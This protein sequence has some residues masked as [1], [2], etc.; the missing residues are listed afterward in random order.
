M[1]G[2]VIGTLAG[3][4]RIVDTI[5]VGG[6]GTVYR[7]EHT[8]LGP[9]RGGEG[10]QPGDVDDAR[11]RQSLLQRGARDHEHQAPRHRRGVRLRLPASRA[12]A[13]IV[14]E[15]LEGEPLARRATRARPRCPRARPRRSCAASA[16]R[17]PPRTPRASSTA[18]SSPTTSSS[19]PIPSRRSAS[20]P[21]CSTSASRSSPTSGSPAAATKTGAVMGT[22]TYMSP[23]QCRGTGDVDHRADLYSLGCI[24]YELRHRPAAVRRS[25][26]GRA[27]RRAPVHAARAAVASRARHLARRRGA[28]HGAAREGSGRAAADRRR[29]R[30]APRCRSRRAAAWSPRRRWDNVARLDAV[31]RGAADADATAACRRRRRAACRCRR[32]AHAQAVSAPMPSHAPMPT[33]GNMPMPTPM[34]ARQRAHAG[35]DDRSDDA[36]GR[37]KPGAGGPRIGQAH[38]RDRRRGRH[39]G[40]HRDLA[41]R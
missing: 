9:A 4:Y 41:S 24:F 27:D 36:V 22:P 29:A 20:A 32:R 28:D 26:R 10:A 15:L 38:L 37:G 5:S 23:E 12:H 21:S 1:I 7:A 2:A 31:R 33:P 39:R 3:S 14:M 34:A 11:H 35:D 25:R 13:Y 19:S 8:L 17:S 30:A 18:T 6:M 16:A 40:R